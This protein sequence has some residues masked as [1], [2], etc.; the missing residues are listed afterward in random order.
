MISKLSRVLITELHPM[1]NISTFLRITVVFMIQLFMVGSAFPQ[2]P[3]VQWQRSDWYPTNPNTGLSQTRD[4]SG[5]DWWYDHINAYDTSGALVGFLAAGYSSFI[6]YTISESSTGGCLQSSLGAPTCSELETTGNVKG[7]PVQTLALISPDGATRAWYRKYNSDWFNRVIQ[8]SDGGFLAIGVTDATRTPAGAPIYYNPNQHL[9]STTDQFTNPTACTLGDNKRHIALI[10]TDAS[11]NIQWQFI[12]GFQPYRNGSGVPDPATAYSSTGEGWD[13]VET[14]AGHFKLVGNATDRNYTY[15]CNNQTTFVNRAVI[16]EVASNGYWISGNLLGPTSAPSNATGIAKYMNSGTLEYVVS[17]TE[18]FQGSSF[19][20]YTGCN[21]FQKV[22]LM[23]FDDPQSTPSWTVTNLD[24]SPTASQ[25]TFDVQISV[26]N[27]NNEIL[28]PAIV[29][30]DGCLYAATN[31]GEGKVYRLNVTGQVISTTSIGQV[32]GYDLRLGVTPTTDGGCG[33]TSTKQLVPPPQPYSCYVTGYWN[34]DAAVAKVNSCGN[35]E[36]ERVF[37]IDV[38]PPAPYPADLKKQECMYSITQADDGGFVVAG[39]NSYNF[40]DTYMAR[41]GPPPSISND[42]YVQDTPQDVGLEPNPDPGPMWVSDDIWVRNN[43]DGGLTHQNPEYS[44]TVPNYVNVRV[45]N[46]SCAPATGRLRVYWA[47]ASTGLSWPSQWVSYSVNGVQFGN[48]LTTSNGIPITSLS[49]NASV[50]VSI[51]WQVPNPADFVSF[52][53][54]KA[55]F[56]LL[57]RVETSLTSPYGFT[58]PEG[59]S[60]NTNVNANN[61]A[62]WKNVTI[63]DNLV[64]KWS[65]KQGCTIIRN[66]TNAASV[67]KLQFNALVAAGG[68]A[69]AG[70]VGG[71][72]GTEKCTFLKYGQITINPG[73]VLFQK[74]INGGSVGRGVRIVNGNELEIIDPNASIDNIQLSANEMDT[75]CAQFLVTTW[76]TVGSPQNYNFDVVQYVSSDSAGSPVGGQRFAISVVGNGLQPIP[77][78][79]GVGVG[80]FTLVLLTTG[81]LLV[82]SMLTNP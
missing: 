1:F 35:L 52:G 69:G 45:R 51:P 57:A 38:L 7:Y 24:Y 53:A 58:F 68:T 28:L 44:P 59:A 74:W 29:N 40:D 9:G 10:K 77:T 19:N 65:G 18:M 80:I 55:H 25:N 70:G 60:I 41:L 71:A 67:V 48:E 46:K 30:C 61:N 62:A 26:N 47:K 16:I 43:N 39:N 15:T 50:I 5:E 36:W 73:V 21:L 14:P 78:L 20:P 4:A 54:D 66:V 27:G 8:T 63:V 75:M 56:C 81:V 49:S 17:G 23:Q 22:N 42:L 34:T 12:Y 76:P 79:S 72:S 2:A 64:N 37:N 3:P 13:V 82:R 31:V 11:G 6:N 32:K 33:V